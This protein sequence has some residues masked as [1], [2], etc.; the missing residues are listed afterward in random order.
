M[1]WIS[2]KDYLPQYGSPV[3]VYSSGVVQYVT[4]CLDICEDDKDCFVPYYFCGKEDNL[5]INT[6]RPT[7]WIYVDEILTPLSGEK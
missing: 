5:T 1:N 4:Y 3:M 6:D 2:T 7:H